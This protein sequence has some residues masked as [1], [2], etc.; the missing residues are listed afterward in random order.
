MD[1]IYSKRQNLL[2]RSSYVCN[3]AILCRIKC[4]RRI[5]THSIIHIRLRTRVKRTLH[6]Y[7]LTRPRTCIHVYNIT[8]IHF[9]IYNSCLH[10]STI[11]LQRRTVC[12]VLLLLLLLLHKYMHNIYIYNNA[13]WCIYIYIGEHITF[14]FTR[15]TYK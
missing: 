9:I 8:H 1:V 6:I 11:A 2:T 15:T 7:T 14:A 4:T 5:Y 10:K 3:S 13:Q 12:N